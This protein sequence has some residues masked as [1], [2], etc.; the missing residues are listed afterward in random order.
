MA[1][2]DGIGCI[3][4]GVGEAPDGGNGH[5]T[6]YIEVVD[7][8][9]SLKRIESFGGNTVTPPMDIPGG[10]SIALFADPEGH[11]VGLVKASSNGDR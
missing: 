6:F 1:H 4:G 7:L 5:V 9:A 3:N 11:V 8:A 2:P 10:P